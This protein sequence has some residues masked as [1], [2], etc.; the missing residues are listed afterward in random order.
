MKILLINNFFSKVGGAENSTNRTGKILRDKGHEV[1]FFSTDKK[2]YFEENYEYAKYF[3]KYID[4]SDLPKSN[5]LRFIFNPSYFY[6]FEAE[7]KLNHYLNDVKPDVVH[8]NCI[9]YYL[10]PSVIRACHKNNIPIVM[11]LRDAF[12]SCPDVGLIY[13]SE[14]YCKDTHCATGN[15]LP[16]ILNKCNDKSLLKSCVSATE[17]ALRKIHRLFDKVSMFICPSNALLE[18]AV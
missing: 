1:Y 16:C 3:P 7:Y 9:T 17:F 18:L 12:M 4:F 13:K 8:C 14:N 2:P 5:F 10:S 11:T 15:P 6:N